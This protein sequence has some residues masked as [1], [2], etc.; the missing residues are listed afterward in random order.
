MAY[1]HTLMYSSYKL[2]Q[3]KLK[4]RNALE[5]LMIISYQFSWCLVKCPSCGSAAEADVLQPDAQKSLL[6]PYPET[7]L[8]KYD[9]SQNAAIYY[10]QSIVFF[11]SCSR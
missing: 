9:P 8:F 2:K 7:F 11:N 10:M 6:D 1:F 4:F 3:I 5:T